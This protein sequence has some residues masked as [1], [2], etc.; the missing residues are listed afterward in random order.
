MELKVNRGDW[1][2]WLFCMV[3]GI[4]AEEA[5][6]R[7]DLGVSYFVFLAVFYTLFFWRFRSFPFSHQRLGYLILII[8]WILGACYYLYD[9]GLFHALNILVIPGLVIFHLALVTSPK[10]MEWSNVFFLLYILQRLFN[11]LRYN[12]RFAGVFGRLF[13]NKTN[14]KNYDTWKKVLIGIAISVP[15]L[16]VVLNLLISADAQFERLL[17]GLP[18]IISFNPEF[19]VRLF[20]ILIYGF[21][22]FGFMQVLLQRNVQPLQRENILKSVSLDGIIVLTVLILLDLVYVLFVGV[23]FTYF[24]SG[25][26]EAGYTYAEYARRGFFEL[27]FV[28][29]INLSVVTVVIVFTKQ[30][31]RYMKLAI[32]LSLTVV[33]LSSCVLLISAFMRMMMYENAYGFT[34][35][36]VLV[37]SFMIFLMII[38]AYTLLKIWLEKL[39]LFHFY[40]IASLLYYAGINVVNIDKIVVDLNIDRYEETGKIDI[41]YLNNLSAT[42]VL[43]LIN[44]YE[45]EPNVQGLEEL[46]KQRKDEREYIHRDS[47]QSRNLTRDKAYEKLGDL[48]FD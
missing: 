3:T 39:A 40:F 33:V 47:W 15:V 13:K 35:T 45:K 48:K 8:I 41:N 12:A 27:L 7:D 24:F 1:I 34:F 30:I 25:T 26:L 5:F 46:L 17:S 14:S 4:V 29:L 2:F 16:F 44:L 11:G 28:T 42:G 10:K 19:L 38:F 20:I 32:R 22:F 37:H 43:G 21:G 23:Q 6:F 18:K 31:Q 36:R 9:T